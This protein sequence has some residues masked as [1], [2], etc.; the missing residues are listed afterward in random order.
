MSKTLFYGYGLAFL[1]MC[2]PVAGKLLWGIPPENMLRDAAAVMEAPAYTGIISNFGF[3]LWSAAATICLLSAATQPRARRFWL[4]AAAITLVLLADDWLLLHE[5]FF[6][7]YLGISEH[8]VYG[9]Y[10]LA[11]LWF[12]FRFRRLLLQSEFPLLLLAFVWFAASLGVD[13]L[14]GYVYMPGFYL[15][16][17]GAKLFGIVSWLAFYGRFAYA[18]ADRTIGQ[19]MT[20]LPDG[21]N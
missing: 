9:T 21:P 11:L 19:R 6:P 17:D 3:F 16:E 4:A 8:V 15:W 20:Q 2:V 12:L 1:V 7:V 14:D 18:M 13:A 10:A 5:N